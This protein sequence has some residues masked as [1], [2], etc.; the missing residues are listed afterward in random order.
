MMNWGTTRVA[1]S[2]EKP[3]THL[4]SQGQNKKHTAGTAETRHP[5]ASYLV[6][7]RFSVTNDAYFPTKTT[8]LVHF[9]STVVLRAVGFF[10]AAGRAT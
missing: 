3:T 4:G 2:L 8:R 6:F 9:V 1:Y 5:G 10:F 7:F